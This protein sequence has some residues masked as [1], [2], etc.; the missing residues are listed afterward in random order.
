MVR[1]RLCLCPVHSC[2]RSWCS[3]AV[4]HI[5]TNKSR[6]LWIFIL[7]SVFHLL[8]HQLCV[9]LHISS[10]YM[11]TYGI[12]NHSVRNGPQNSQSNPCL[13]VWFCS[14]ILGSIPYLKTSNYNV[15][16]SQ[17]VSSLCLSLYS[18]SIDHT[19]SVLFISLTC[20]HIPTHNVSST[21]ASYIFL[22]RIIC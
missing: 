6:N 13:S 4:C 8:G 1:P 21:I 12:R 17:Q 15:E 18:P 20:T 19:P 5:P 11:K 16:E 7:W 14:P 10:L 9:I 3:L 22:S 2:W